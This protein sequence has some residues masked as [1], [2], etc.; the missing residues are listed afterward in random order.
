MKLS[1]LIS[2][3]SAIV[4]YAIA[5]T[6]VLF[7]PI[8][9]N[10]FFCISMNGNSYGDNVKCIADYIR[11]H[12]SNTEIIWAFSKFFYRTVKCREIRVKLF[13]IK[14]YYH[15]LTSKYI[16]TNCS[17]GP[18]HILKKRKSQVCVNMWH[19]TALKR[20]GIDIFAT[21]KNSILF[22]YFNFNYVAYTSKIT[23]YFVS[24]SSY[25][26]E[27]IKTKLLFKK[28]IL[29]IGTPRNDIFFQKRED[30]SL[31]IRSLYNIQKGEKII[32]YAPTFRDDDSLFGYDVN[33]QMIKNELSKKFGVDY[34]ILIK[35]HPSLIKKTNMFSKLFADSTDV[36]LYPDMQDL[37]YSADVLITDYSSSMFDFMYSNKLV[38][39][40]VNDREKYNRGF[41]M[42]IEDL[43]FLILNSNAEICNKI[44]GFQMTSYEKKVQL[45]LNKIGSV[46]TGEATKKLYEILCNNE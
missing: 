13:T 18:L 19:G 9:R 6:V 29:E 41:Y 24:G 30:V 35:L 46:E 44:D 27:I 20:I 23:D 12:T 34:Q 15:I 25:M 2:Y 33:L 37:L 7:S 40:Y 4:S 39:L 8:K 36:S 45:F 16:L 42:N 28:E 43:P 5:R 3:T 10:K 38:I 26:T 1:N 21:K 22:K 14:Y 31:K 11:D 32:L 17:F